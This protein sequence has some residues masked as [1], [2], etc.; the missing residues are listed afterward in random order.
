MG[1]FV[2]RFLS[3]GWGRHWASESFITALQLGCFSSK[4]T[5]SVSI[6]L[7]V[8]QRSSQ[9]HVWPITTVVALEQTSTNSLGSAVLP[10]FRQIVFI[11]Q[12]VLLSVN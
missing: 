4:S 9:P 2:F 3:N 5:Q 6:L 8:A 10:L 12:F 11:Q 1:R 7:S